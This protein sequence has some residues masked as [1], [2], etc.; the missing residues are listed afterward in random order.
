MAFVSLHVQQG[1]D[2]EPWHRTIID[3]IIITDRSTRYVDSS[4][5]T[6]PTVFPNLPSSYFYDYD[7]ND[8]FWET[9]V[10][11]PE[12]VAGDEERGRG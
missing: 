7:H 11:G 6:H 8:P 3:V 5:D 1:N 9:P 12:T 2:P 10:S 4:D